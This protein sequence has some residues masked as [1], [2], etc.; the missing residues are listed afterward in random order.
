MILFHY[1]K[2]YTGLKTTGR[3]MTNNA[4]PIITYTYFLHTQLIIHITHRFAYN[5]AMARFICNINMGNI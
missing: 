1:I 2:M 3:E 5:R 4:G